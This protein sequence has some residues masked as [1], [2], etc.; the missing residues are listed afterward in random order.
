M[1][2]PLIGPQTSNEY[3]ARSLAARFSVDLFHRRTPNPWRVIV[4]VLLVV[5]ELDESVRITVFEQKVG[6]L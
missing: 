6:W 4:D 5:N 1:K 2:E 3:L